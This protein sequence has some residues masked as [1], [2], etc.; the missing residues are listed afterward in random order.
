MYMNF[1]VDHSLAS[2]LIIKF[3]RSCKKILSKLSNSKIFELII[4]FL[5]LHRA[6]IRVNNLDE[7]ESKVYFLSETT[8]HTL[9]L[10]TYF[11]KEC[12]K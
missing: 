11:R 5:S 12:K 9:G 8:Y 2:Y 7:P 4:F 3:L 1:L 10:I 6:I